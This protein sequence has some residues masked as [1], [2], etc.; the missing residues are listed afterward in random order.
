MAAKDALEELRRLQQLEQQLETDTRP[1]CPFFAKVGACRYGPTCSRAHLLP[2]E[3]TTILLPNMHSDPLLLPKQ[4]TLNLEDEELSEEVDEKQLQQN[5]IEFFEDTHDEFLGV[6]EVVQFKVCRNQTPH[7]RGNVYVQ[8]KT[9]AQAAA[10]VQKFNNRFFG[11]MRLAAYLVTV[12]SW[13]SAICGTRGCPRGK[14][15]ISCM[16]LGIRVGF[17]RT[18]ITTLERVMMGDGIGVVGIDIAIDL[19][20][21]AEVVVV[22]VVVAD[23]MKEILKEMVVVERGRGVVI[24]VNAMVT[25]GIGT[26]MKEETI[27]HQGTGVMFRGIEKF[28]VA[29]EVWTEAL[30]GEWTEVVRGVW[31]EALIETMEPGEG[32][33][34]GTLAVS[35]VGMQCTVLQN[36]MEVWKDEKRQGDKGRV[37]HYHRHMHL[38]AQLMIAVYHKVA[39]HQM[40]RLT[41]M[42]STLEGQQTTDALAMNDR[43]DTTRALADEI[44]NKRTLKKRR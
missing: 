35:A 26:G 41:C 9:P 13:K 17:I 34:I 19:G 25:D 22:E 8:Y 27:L 29:T 16:C 30:I 42:G 31:I 43:T 7:L 6:G 20:I 10:A 15:A 24:E 36:V 44:T 32:A 14:C 33:V 28:V 18:L 3:S 38:V 40:M 5:F 39:G 2:P 1:A 4:R 21:E 23:E 11:G 12:P 37:L